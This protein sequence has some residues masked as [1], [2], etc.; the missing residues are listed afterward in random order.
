MCGIAGII[1]WDGAPVAER[2]LRAMCGSM[3]HRGP[4]DEGLYLTQ[5]L[6]AP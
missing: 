2:E 3:S 4:D 1:R 6:F 5:G